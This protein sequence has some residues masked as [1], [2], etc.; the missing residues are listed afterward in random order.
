M[1]TH[2]VQT[3]WRHGEIMSINHLRE[4]LRG[5]L[6]IR[7]DRKIRQQTDDLGVGV[8]EFTFFVRFGGIH[9]DLRH[10]PYSREYPPTLEDECVAVFHI[11]PAYLDTKR[12]DD[13]KD[14]VI[15]VSL[16]CDFVP[17]CRGLPVDGAFL[18]ATLP[19][20]GGRMGGTFESWFSIA[21]SDAEARE[22]SAASRE[23]VGR[24]SK[25][26]KEDEQ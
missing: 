7:F 23:S 10:L 9:D 3:N 20:H 16:K 25:P 5:R 18:G 26:R 17:D 8:S 1:L 4:K 11:D 6:E 14:K 22:R 19:T 13:L 15:Y 12:R 2:I 21:E 24:R